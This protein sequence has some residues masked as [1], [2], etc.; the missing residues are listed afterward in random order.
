M[1]VAT[2]SHHLTNADLVSRPAGVN[3]KNSD[4]K[5]LLTVELVSEGSVLSC[6][7]ACVA[8]GDGGACGAFCL[9]SPLFLFST[10]DLNNAGL[11]MGGTRCLATSGTA[12]YG[13]LGIV[14]RPTE[15][16]ETACSGS[17]YA[18][19]G[20]DSLALYYRNYV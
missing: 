20:V 15:A 8:H 13:S 4:E 12:Y 5:D 19:G 17:T 1:Y 10:T 2:S 16:C 14:S 3:N 11:S 9:F 6:L 18:C 7:E